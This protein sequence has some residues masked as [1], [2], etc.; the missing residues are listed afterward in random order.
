MSDI[1]ENHPD[2]GQNPEGDPK[3]YKIG[4]H[5]P[6]SV[7]FVDGVCYWGCPR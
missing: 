2:D 1:P 7:C 5:V 6:E 4:N 3:Q